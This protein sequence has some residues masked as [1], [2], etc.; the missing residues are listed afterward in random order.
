MIYQSAKCVKS[1]LPTATCPDRAEKHPIRA[2]CIRAIQCRDRQVSVSDTPPAF[3]SS[4]LALSDQTS[5]GRSGMCRGGHY[6]RRS[7]LASG[8]AGRSCGNNGRRL[9]APGSPFGFR[10]VHLLSVVAHADCHFAAVAADESSRWF[11]SANASF[12]RHS[13]YRPGRRAVVGVAAH[14]T[15]PLRSL[16]TTAASF[17]QA[18]RQ[19]KE[20]AEAANRAKSELSHGLGR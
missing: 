9:L 6:S 11:H 4:A 20:A 17:G 12:A 19:A 18:L 14:V 16:V 13:E 8:R 5:V 3:G 10:S 1:A 2:N 7:D 15:T